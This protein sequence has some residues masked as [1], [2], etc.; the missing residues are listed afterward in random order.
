MLVA[1]ACYPVLWIVSVVNIATYSTILIYIICMSNPLTGLLSRLRTKITNFII[2]ETAADMSMRIMRLERENRDLRFRIRRF[3]K[4]NM[5]FDW[6]LRRVLIKNCSNSECIICREFINLGDRFV[7]FSCCGGFIIH[8]DCAN[9]WVREKRDS[10][11]LVCLR[12]CKSV[13]IRS[14]TP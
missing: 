7:Y 9:K 8:H 11:C 5:T 14:T 3:K 12:K 1:W 2:G 10:C 4:A 13:L 6:I